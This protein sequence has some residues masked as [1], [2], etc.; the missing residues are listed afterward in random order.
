MNSTPDSPAELDLSAQAPVP[1][2]RTIVLVGFMGAGKTSVGR[3]LSKRL[4]WAFEDLDDR[5]QA[6]EQRTIEDIFRNSGEAAFR[7]IEHDALRAALSDRKKACILALGGGA[8]VQSSNAELLKS[9]GLPVVFLDA[10][11]YSG[12]AVWTS[13]IVRCAGRLSSFRNCISRAG[14]ITRPALCA[15]KLAGKTPRAWPPK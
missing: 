4:G 11:N 1:A 9:A 14:R 7:Q 5:I 13:M 3:I 10:R 6:R 12:A 2:L 8:F 15:S